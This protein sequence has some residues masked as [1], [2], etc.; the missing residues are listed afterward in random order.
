MV[1]PKMPQ[2]PLRRAVRDLRQGLNRSRQLVHDIAQELAP[3]SYGV[4]TSP[5]VETHPPKATTS[6]MYEG[7]SD[8]ETLAYQWERILDDLQ[9]LETEHLPM[10]GRI[11]NRACDCIAKAARD[12]RRH[13]LETVP[14]AARQGVSTGILD[15]I[16]E[17][18][19][20]MIS[21]GT[22]QAVNSGKY[23]DEYLRQ[24]GIASK[25][26]KEIERLKGECRTCP[27]MVDLK[28]FLEDR[29]KRGR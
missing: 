1:L 15:E 19:Q 10:K 11:G 28:K 12:L 14:I 23:N 7:V 8:A 16:G 9:H 3:S 22:L 29:Q 24:A 27:T 17:W 4:S 25:Y 5:P 18:A 6:P 21:I 20:H 26:R 13:A 2:N